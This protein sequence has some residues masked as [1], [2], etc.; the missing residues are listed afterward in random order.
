MMNEQ[1][2]TSNQYDLGKGEIVRIL[3]IV[4]C[5]KIIPLGNLGHGTTLRGLFVLLIS[6]TFGGVLFP[7]LVRHEDRLHRLYQR[8]RRQKS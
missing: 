1:R 2:V 8:L 5:S 4:L 6:H 7:L 3:R